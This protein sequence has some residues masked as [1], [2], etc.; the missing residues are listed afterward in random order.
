MTAYFS[1]I[2]NMTDLFLATEK[3]KGHVCKC[4][5][6]TISQVCFRSLTNFSDWVID[7]D[8][9]GLYRKLLQYMKAVESRYETDIC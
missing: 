3:F 1:A 4:F 8:T 7:G 5:S 2:N 9:T 6:G